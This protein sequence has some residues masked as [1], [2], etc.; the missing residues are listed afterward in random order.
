[1][2]KFY[3]LDNSTKKPMV[4][5]IRHSHNISERVQWTFSNICATFTNDVRGEYDEWTRSWEGYTMFCSKSGGT[6]STNK[7]TSLYLQYYDSGILRNNSFQL[8]WRMFICSNLNHILWLQLFVE[9]ILKFLTTDTR[10]IVIWA[11]EHSQM[12]M[13]AY[14]YL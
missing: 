9:N 6:L 8:H 12:Q 4:A 2:L 7:I 1:M 11:F 10:R 3:L 5:T 13:K 14:A